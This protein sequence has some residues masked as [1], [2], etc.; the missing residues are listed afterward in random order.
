MGK[1]IRDSIS[2]YTAQGQMTTDEFDRNKHT[3]FIRV[4]DDGTSYMITVECPE[5][6]LNCAHISKSPVVGS[7][8]YYDTGEFTPLHN[9]KDRLPEWFD[10]TFDSVID[11]IDTAIENLYSGNTGEGHIPDNIVEIGLMII[12]FIKQANVRYESD[13]YASIVSAY[14]KRFSESDAHTILG[15]M[16]SVFKD[17][18]TDSYI[19]LQAASVFCKAAMETVRIAE[20]LPEHDF[21]NGKIAEAQAI[22]KLFGCDVMLNQFLQC[23][24]SAVNLK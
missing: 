8:G 20:D 23:F 24:T 13:V 5:H 12:D 19:A 22:A 15:A 2:Y 14:A 11:N 21:C 16:K 3:D 18:A 6:K 9:A 7:Y 1:F 10:A 17:K 4:Y